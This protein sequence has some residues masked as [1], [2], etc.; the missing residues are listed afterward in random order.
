MGTASD[1]RDWSVV[2][3][4]GNPKIGASEYQA[5]QDLGSKVSFVA[6][7]FFSLPAKS[8]LSLK[9]FA[10]VHHLG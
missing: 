5:G 6:W 8:S 1:A 10:V 3:A 7:T 2:G 4:R 9:Q